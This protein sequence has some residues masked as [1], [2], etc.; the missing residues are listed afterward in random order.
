MCA[1]IMFL[2]STQLTNEERRWVVGNSRWAKDGRTFVILR[3]GSRRSN[4]DRNSCI[5]VRLVTFYDCKLDL[6]HINYFSKR[7]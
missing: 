6:T 4:A 3:V 5:Y 7:K 1:D 2:D